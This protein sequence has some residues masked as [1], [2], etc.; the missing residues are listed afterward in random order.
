MI[1][2]QY[3]SPIP[4]DKKEKVVDSLGKRRKTS[5][6]EDVSSHDKCGAFVSF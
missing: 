3:S 5:Q 4:Q 6:S 2:P 1:F